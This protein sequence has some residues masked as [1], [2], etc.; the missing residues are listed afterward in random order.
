MTLQ[1]QLDTEVFKLAW[2][3]SYSSPCARALL[4]PKAYMLC[5]YYGIILTEIPCSMFCLY[6]VV[7]LPGGMHLYKPH[8]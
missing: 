6:A 3:I 1:F 2:R 5:T 4:Q 7:I 8:I